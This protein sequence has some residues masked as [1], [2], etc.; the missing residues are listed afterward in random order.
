M[1]EDGYPEDQEL[2][3]ISDW[4]ILKEPITD[5]LSYIKERWKYADCGYYQLTGRRVL[6]LRLSTAGW[7]GNESIVDALHKNTLFWMICW[8]QSKKGG[9]YWFRIQLNQFK[10]LIK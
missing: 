5:L 3:R 7:S 10:P 9:H 8:E 2:K 6:R 1:D 4:D